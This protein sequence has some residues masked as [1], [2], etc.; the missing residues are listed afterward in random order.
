MVS[1]RKFYLPK[2]SC[3]TVNTVIIL[4]FPLYGKYSNYFKVVTRYGYIIGFFNPPEKNLPEEK[5]YTVEWDYYS[6]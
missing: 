6:I 5:H 3:Y 1:F 4:N 2:I